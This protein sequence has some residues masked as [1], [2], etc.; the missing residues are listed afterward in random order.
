MTI[1]ENRTT[2]IVGLGEIVVTREPTAVLT[3]VGLGSCIAMCIYDP[4]AKLGGLVHMLL[5]MSNS[6][7]MNFVPS[8]YV[9]TGVPL[10]INRMIKQ[11]AQKSR[12][13]AKMTGGARMLAIPGGST[14][15]DIGTRNISEAKI[16]MEK[17]ALKLVSAEV[18]GN[19]GRTIQF[20]LNTGK[21]F[22][23]TAGGQ[24]TEL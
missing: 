6:T 5:P 16:A 14:R 12:M 7:D 10:L 9:N 11:G 22:V 13:V 17:E 1:T 4:V 18:G 23:R 21:I 2:I 8:K 20:F 19:A 3:C 15:M 24:I